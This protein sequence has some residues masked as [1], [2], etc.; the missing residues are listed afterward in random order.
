MGLLR[1]IPSAA[2]SF[3]ISLPLFLSSSLYFISLLLGFSFSFHHTHHRGVTTRVGPV[4]VS[5][6]V[7]R[8]AVPARQDSLGFG[9]RTEREAG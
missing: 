2:L 6:Y 3:C 5:V 9:C 8:S 7:R 1:T 4:V